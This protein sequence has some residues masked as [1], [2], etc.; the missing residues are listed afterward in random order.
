MNI[1]VLNYEWPPL[2]GGA[3]PV[4]EQLCRHFAAMGHTVEVVS[5]GFKGLP[6]REVREGVKITRVPALRKR[7]ATCE[8]HEMLSYVLSAFPGVVSR[9]RRNLFDIV[10]V[11]FVIPTGLLAFLATRFRNIPYVITAHGSDIPG[12]NPDRFQKEH[13]LT[14]PLL[15][16]IMRHAA[17]LTSPSQFLRGLMIKACGPFE[18][19][20]IPNGIDLGRFT[21]RTKARRLLM[22][23]RLLPRKGFQHVLQALQGVETDFEVHIAGDGPMRQEMETLAKTL[24]TKVVFHGW[25]DNDSHEL[26]DLYETSSIFCLPSERENASISLL[27]A[28]AAGMAVITSDVTGCPETLGDAGFV[29]PPCDPQAIRP[30]LEKLMASETLTA[31]YGEKARQRIRE[32][33][34][35]RTISL[36]Y[37]SLF[38]SVVEARPNASAG[39]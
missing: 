18:I 21:P 35:W 24:R 17:A 5:M 33:F 2:G 22:T 8:T 32:C 29:V 27:E 23:G 28:M 10:H 14:T 39:G 11:H 19:A 20:H 15:K 25:L 12:Y 37:M 6:S 4:G 7:Q 13:H 9:L 1:L 38:E 3:A 16:T 31:E 26:K 36:E 30:V 34:D